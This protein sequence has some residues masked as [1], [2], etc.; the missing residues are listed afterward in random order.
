MLFEKGPKKK[1]TPYLNTYNTILHFCCGDFKILIN[2]ID[3]I[4]TN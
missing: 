3:L 1:R 2:L 4:N